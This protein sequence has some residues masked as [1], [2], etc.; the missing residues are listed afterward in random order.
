MRKLYEKN[1]V[2]FALVWIALYVVGMNIAMQFC[3]GFDGLAGKTAGQL[4]VPVICAAALAVAS[5][6]WIVKNDLAEK[7]GLCSFKG[8]R[9]AFL[10]FVPLVVMS[11]KVMV[12]LWS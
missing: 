5:T 10:W 1:E 7:F 8:S 12:P 9:K 6:V 3:G 2:T 4:I 11:L